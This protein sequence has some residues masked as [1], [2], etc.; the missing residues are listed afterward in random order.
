MDAKHNYKHVNKFNNQVTFFLPF[1]A[2]TL[3]T[4]CPYT[5]YILRL[6]T[7]QKNYHKKVS[8]IQKFH[9][10]EKQNKRQI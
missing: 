10:I 1:I 9:D 2:I 6:I 8:T 3:T 4:H 5:F 7:K